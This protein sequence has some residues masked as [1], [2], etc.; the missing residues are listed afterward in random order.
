MTKNQSS[1]I[2]AGRQLTLLSSVERRCLDLVRV[3]VL[4]AVILSASAFI[5][6]GI[7]YGTLML[8]SPAVHF[9]DRF[10]TPAW[11]DVRQGVLPLAGPEN[12]QPAGEQ[13]P[14]AP[15]RTGVDPRIAEIAG[16][17]N[18][19]FARNR[20]QQT[21]FSD[22]YPR[23]SLASWIQ[24]RAGIPPGM[25][26]D[27]IEALRRVSQAI[28]EDPLINRIGSVPDRV[29]TM[30]EA[31]VA[32]R[33]E[34]TQRAR[35]VR[36]EVVDANRALAAAREASTSS[37]LMLGGGAAAVMLSLL[38]VIVLMRIEV[39]LREVNRY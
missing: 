21:A 37:A 31:L 7:W 8:G 3:A 39:H 23:R 18:K 29:A 1:P 12:D 15:E 17:L 22:A 35:A 27:F 32:Y 28:G 14:G 10:E 25:Q 26:E 9:D 11:D 36:N 20:D 4:V 30:R 34:Y 38:L 16:N 24:D 19:Q 13:A 5:V 6:A 33:D 2:R